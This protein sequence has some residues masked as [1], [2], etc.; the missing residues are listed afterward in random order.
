ERR[1]RPRTLVRAGRRVGSER[2]EKEKPYLTARVSEL[3]D[4]VE[5]GPEL[6]AL[7]RNVQQT[8]RQIIEDVPY[9][10]E[11]LQMAWANL[12]DPSALSHL[13]AGALRIKTEDRQAL[14]EEVDV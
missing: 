14:L 6:T 8:F 9:P 2:W 12:D 1:D 5:E 7:M 13:I 4:V 11:E 3:P 10:P